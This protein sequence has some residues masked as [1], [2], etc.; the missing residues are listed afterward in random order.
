[1]TTKRE[2]ENN[3]LGTLGRAADHTRLWPSQLFYP[4]LIEKFFSKQKKTCERG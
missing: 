2:L 1:M 4:P 3:G